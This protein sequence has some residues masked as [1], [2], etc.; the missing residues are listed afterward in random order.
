MHFA[1]SNPLDFDDCRAKPAP[2]VAFS[3]MPE[4]LA[5]IKTAW[6]IML[7]VN[8]PQYEGGP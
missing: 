2:A 6:R 1:I 4:N 5:L 8:C 3:M 7:I